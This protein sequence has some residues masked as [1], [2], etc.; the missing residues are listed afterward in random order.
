MTQK[1]IFSFSFA[2]FVNMLFAQEKLPTI[3]A[4]SNIVDVRDG[5]NF[6]KGN[7]KITPEVKPDV[8]ITSSKG[9]KVTFYTDRDSISVKITPTTKF[10]FII[11]LNDTTRAFTEILFK[12]SYLDILKTADNYNINDKRYVPKF[13]YQ[14]NKDS[15]LVAIRKGFKLDSIAG[16]GNEVSKILNLLLWVHNVIPHDGNHNNP[17]IKNALSMIAECKRDNRGLN[18]RGL[19][20]VLNECYLSLGIP[21]RIVTCMPS[22]SVFND[23]H[24][25]NMVYAKDLKKWLWID[26]TNYAYVMNEKGEL[27][28]IEEVRDRI[29]HN[30]PIILNPDAN[31]NHKDSKTKQEYLYQ[32]MAKNLFRMECPLESKYDNETWKSGNT[33]SYVEL[34]PL[35]AYNQLPQKT[36][37]IPQLGITITNY[38]TNN[39]R[40]FWALPE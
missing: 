11:L 19:A 24:V 38:K 40:L 26:P 27:L 21:S 29:I 34:L 25:I 16:E 13:T 3:K 22:D 17:V 23:C 28:S 5:D 36:N 14:S 6:L 12:P 32:Y 18:C 20:T 15:N 8:F 30:K 39:P 4:T 10:D 33:I 31:W 2:L 9:Q 35:N 1:L 7:W 37:K